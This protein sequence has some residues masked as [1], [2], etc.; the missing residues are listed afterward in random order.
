MTHR[1]LLSAASLMA[2]VFPFASSGEAPPSPA[3]FLVQSADQAGIDFTNQCGGREKN[4]ILEANGNGCALVDLDRDGLLD[5]VM[6]SGSTM[7][8]WQQ[9]GGDPVV[10]IYRN[11]GSRRFENITSRIRGDQQG[12]GTGVSITDVN[13]D[14]YPDLYVTGFGRNYLYINEGGQAFAESAEGLGLRSSGW[15]TGAAWA[16]FDRDGD[17]DVYVARYV[18]IDMKN[19][20]GPLGCLYF[21]ERVFCGPRGLQGAPDSYYVQQNG[22]FVE[23]GSDR[24]TIDP[25][26]YFGF[27][28]VAFDYDNDGWADVYVANDTNRNFLFHN[29]KG[30]LR[31]V[32]MIAGA[33]LSE[34]GREQSGMGVEAADLNNDG[35][36]DLVVTNFSGDYDTVYLNRKGAYFT[37]ASYRMGIAAPTLPALG[38]GVSA[39]DHDNDGR[40]DLFFANGHVYPAADKLRPATAYLQPLQLFAAAAAGR[41]EPVPLGAPPTQGRGV[42]A[43]DID[44]DGDVDLLVNIQGGRPLLL[45]NQQRE[46]DPSRGW[47]TLELIPTR[48]IPMGAKVTVTA[49]GKSQYRE[50]IVN[51]GYLSAGDLRLHFGLAD[52]RTADIS[53]EWPGGG[54]ETWPGV[55]T[56][57][58]VKLRQGGSAQRG[59]GDGRI[60]RPSGG[61][62]G[63][64]GGSCACARPAGP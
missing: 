14:G 3:P 16:D 28:A 12:W 40:L 13:L 46:R 31:E 27:D 44:N 52:A 42:A 2:A 56:N 55:S 10:S 63:L 6:V 29:E 33:A 59:G 37:D 47:L 17:L 57:Q 9:A 51:H 41:F 48:G 35:W 18:E 43:G 50:V 4:Y 8:R 60:S 36:T 7:E 53:V 21:G 30:S 64:A 15:S 54:K 58:S 38:W 23:A 45:W 39:L 49:G 20:P 22:R 34:D 5:V 19:L 62:R 61:R 11:L 24:G 26:K 1:A 25:D 32:G